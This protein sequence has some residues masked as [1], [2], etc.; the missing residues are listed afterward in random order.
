MNEDRPNTEIAS[1]QVRPSPGPR[2]RDRSDRPRKLPPHY[3]YECM[4]RTDA[5]RKE[6]QRASDLCAWPGCEKTR[7]GDASDYGEVP[8]CIAHVYETWRLARD[9]AERTQ[10]QVPALTVTD[11]RTK[12]TSTVEKPTSKV[13]WVYYL[14]VDGHIKVGYASNLRNRLKAYPPTSEFLYAHRGTKATEK[15]AHSMLYLWLAQGREWFED[16]PEVLEYVAAQER[17]YG[18]ARDPRL[19]A[20]N[21]FAYLED[22]TPP[23]RVV[24]G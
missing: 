8:L 20:V 15:V 3:P 14:R 7:P 16:R 1:G 21:Q 10:N 9:L 23:I 12:E 5:M 18:P 2:R 13:G 24:R 17:R 11:W 6:S 4:E 19:P 22:K